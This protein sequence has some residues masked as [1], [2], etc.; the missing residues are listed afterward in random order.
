MKQLFI[1]LDVHK[2]TWAVTIQE[3]HLIL[4]RFTIEADAGLLIGYVSRHFP[5]HRVQCCY[6][7]CCCGYHIYHS[8][9]AAGWE[10]LVVNPGDWS[11]DSHWPAG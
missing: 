11:A 4:K 8:L 5:H 9:T 6:E 10:V 2:K 1:G 7:C 3:D